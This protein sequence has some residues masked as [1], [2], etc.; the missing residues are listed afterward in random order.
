VYT[1]LVVIGVFIEEA[2]SFISWEFIARRIPLSI[3]LPRHRLLFW[4]KAVAKLGWFL[5][6]LGVAGEGVYEGYVS[7]ADG[8]LQE[9]NNAL[10]MTAQRQASDA[11]GEAA[12]ANERA[13]HEVLERI[14]LERELGPRTFS[15]EQIDR[16]VAKLRPFAG[17]SVWVMAYGNETKDE[18]D[19]SIGFAKSIW[20]ALRRAGI[21]SEVAWSSLDWPIQGVWLAYG[22]TDATKASGLFSALQR[23][24]KDEGLEIGP[25]ALGEAD[26]PKDI[27]LG[28]AE[29]RSE[30]IT[31]QPIDIR[32]IV[33]KKPPTI[34]KKKN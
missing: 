24:M 3:L 21:R 10:L 27:L 7:R 15:Q 22:S 14:R 11:I 33:G 26:L 16:L 25:F 2:E 9:F 4:A 17:M 13:Q 6:V 31:L 29:T 32:I 5:I 1:A 12:D 20:S 18:K 34:L 28:L 19:E 23:A 30:G 8:L